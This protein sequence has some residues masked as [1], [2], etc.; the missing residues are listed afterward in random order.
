[1]AL[2]AFPALYTIEPQLATDAGF[3]RDKKWGLFVAWV[4]ILFMAVARL[5]SNQ[6][7]REDALADRTAA[8]DGRI[9]ATGR[10]Q[11]EIRGLIDGLLDV[12]RQ[13]QLG[14]LTMG[15]M[16]RIRSAQEQIEYAISL[17]TQESGAS[18]DL[19]ALPDDSSFIVVASHLAGDRQILYPLELAGNGNPS[20]VRSVVNVF[21]L[22]QSAL[23]GKAAL[24]SVEDQHRARL[25]HRLKTTRGAIAAPLLDQD[26]LQIGTLLVCSGSAAILQEDIRQGLQKRVVNIAEEVAPILC[27]WLEASN[28]DMRAE[29]P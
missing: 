17:A 8:I 27:Q 4:L 9:L 22:N 11:A 1:V 26:A 19:P 18:T 23:H 28:N 6:S 24:L 14:M 2:A 16:A 21:Q 3:W 13:T 12:G 25:P 20:A 10:A 7:R 15:S 5:T 29:R